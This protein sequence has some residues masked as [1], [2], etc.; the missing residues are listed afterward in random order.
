MD[1]KGN[2]KGGCRANGGKAKT[3]WRRVQI[4]MSVPQIFNSRFVHL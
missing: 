1:W 4:G 2:Q 3:S